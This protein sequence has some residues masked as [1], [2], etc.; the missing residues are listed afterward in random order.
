MDT[1]A[2]RA[3]AVAAVEVA[4][5]NLFPNRRKILPKTNFL[6]CCIIRINKVFFEA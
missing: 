2:L 3:E 1:A 4:V 5:A 6:K